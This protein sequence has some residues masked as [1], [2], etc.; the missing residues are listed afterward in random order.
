[1]RYLYFDC[2]CNPYW[3]YW[4]GS[5]GTSRSICD[6]KS[7]QS[8][9]ILQCLMMSGDRVVSRYTYDDCR[10]SGCIHWNSIGIWTRNKRH[11]WTNE[12][13]AFPRQL[14]MPTIEH[15]TVQLVLSYYTLSGFMKPIRR[16]PRQVRATMK[17]W[18][19][20][21]SERDFQSS[22]QSW[23]L[24]QTAVWALKKNE[25]KMT[26]WKWDNYNQFSSALEYKM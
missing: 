23:Y 14:L 10:A 24:A 25:M 22:W 19:N 20:Y 8:R 21:S 18:D 6:V 2:N 15:A 26:E 5:S 4:P 7:R 11:E 13:I 16:K 9:L 1:M 17:L 12:K 3:I